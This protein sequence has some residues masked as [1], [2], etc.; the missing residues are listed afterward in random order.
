MAVA[1]SGQ[2]IIVGCRVC[3]Q[4]DFNDLKRCG[5][6]GTVSYCSTECQHKDWVAHRP[7]C[8][9][10]K[11][12]GIKQ[13]NRVYQSPIANPPQVIS[14]GQLV[15]S[16]KAARIK[17]RAGRLHPLLQ[18]SEESLGPRVSDYGE[19]FTQHNS[20]E[21]MCAA[22]RDLDNFH[23]KVVVP[24][25]V[26]EARIAVI[27][28]VSTASPRSSMSR[29]LARRLGLQLGDSINGLGYGSVSCP[30]F[31]PA[32]KIAVFFADRV[33]GAHVLMCMA[34]V[35]W[36]RDSYS[37]LVIGQDVYEMFS[38][39]CYD[40][41]PSTTF[42]RGISLSS[43]DPGPDPASGR[44]IEI[45]MPWGLTEGPPEMR[46]PNSTDM[47]HLVDVEPAGLL[48]LR[49]VLDRPEFC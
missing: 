13:H 29:R 35:V 44:L 3:L 9:R 17:G 2:T 15:R 41:T 12:E 36:A 49:E 11:K 27:A 32:V 45:E 39:W 22:L 23:V 16:G 24:V 5:G 4:G 14:I 47:S 38:E 8:K 43:A 34:P 18:Q 25:L 1:R 26:G 42:L 6:C 20:S 10:L 19:L 7:I 37:D 28:G 30:A 46:K 21:D 33:S 31:A 48:L 40:A